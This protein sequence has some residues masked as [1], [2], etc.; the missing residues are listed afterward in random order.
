MSLFHRLFMTC[1]ALAVSMVA[2]LTSPYSIAG[3]VALGATRIVYPLDER[4]V[5][6]PITN[7]DDK[8]RFLIK[9][10][11]EDSEGKKSADITT[12]PPLF[13]IAPGNEHILSIKLNASS[14]LPSDRE[15]L[16]WLNAQ[17]IPQYDA[18]KGENVLQLAALSKIKIF[19]RPSGLDIKPL[20]APNHLSFSRQGESL[21]VHNPTPYHITLVSIMEGDADLPNVMVPPKESLTM[22]S[23]GKKGPITFRTINDYGA[24]TDIKEGLM[25]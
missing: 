1:N 14:A 18:T 3:G 5:T 22:K 16:Y 8:S 20:E 4:Q 15:T 24:I 12:T 17:A 23:S 7:T 2:A 21:V 13:M 10:W 9:S 6:L 11:A 25:K 19:V